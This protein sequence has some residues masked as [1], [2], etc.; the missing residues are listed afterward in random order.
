MIF[1]AGH[2]PIPQTS[3]HF[4]SWLPYGTK[5]VKVL[6]LCGQSTQT[7]IC[8]FLLT[9]INFVFLKMKL[10]LFLH[11]FIHP[12]SMAGSSTGSRT[13]RRS[14]KLYPLGVICDVGEGMASV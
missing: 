13:T 2:H 3:C 11:I 12:T 5:N 4:H 6:T 1:Q 10:K 7:W 14:C 8:F 9:L